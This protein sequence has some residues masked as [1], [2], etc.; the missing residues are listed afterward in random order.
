MTFCMTLL[1]LFAGVAALCAAQPVHSLD[2]PVKP[3]RFIVPFPPGGTPD[4]LARVIGEKL[5]ERW[6][7]QVLIE[8]RLGAGGNVAYGSVATAAPDGYTILQAATGIVTNV[9]L[10]RKVPYDLFKDFAPITLLAT[11]PHVLVANSSVPA[12]SVKELIALAKAKPG[13]L[14]FGS[15][16]SGTVL[17]LAGEMFKSLSGVNLLHVP[18]KG[19][20]PALTDLLGG[21][22]AL[23]F[24]DISPALPH[25]KTGRLRAL[26]LT[27]AKRSPALPDVPPIAEVGLPRYDLVAWF[28]LLA[29]SG[30]NKEIV[31][32]IYQD[33]AVIVNIPE[34]R[35]RMLDQGV[36]LV[37]NTP[38]QFAAYIKSEFAVM[39]KIVKDSGARAD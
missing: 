19:S 26:G 7:Q 37:G 34:V 15:A 10:Y 3:V 5:G 13:E 35:A 28:G 8:N 22:I 1:S 6:N 27:G 24:I 39:A 23:M 16:G 33:V 4:T 9:S 2:Y 12:T 36:E 29:P 14:A 31:D 17:H 11:S 32:K 30:T 38:A 25:L 18:Y 20:Q 21:R